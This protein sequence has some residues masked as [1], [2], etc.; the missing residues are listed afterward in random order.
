MS[1]RLKALLPILATVS[2]FCYYKYREAANDYFRFNKKESYS[3]K[4]EFAYQ[5]VTQKLNIVHR[6]RNYVPSP[7]LINYYAMAPAVDF[8]AVGDLDNDGFSDLLFTTATQGD[9]LKVYHNINGLKFEDVG[10]QWGFGQEKKTENMVYAIAV[11]DVNND[12]WLDVYLSRDPCH[13]LYI[14]NKGHFMPAGE[15]YGVSKICGKRVTGIAV[16]DFNRDGFLDLYFT[17]LFG[18]SGMDGG[19][20][21]GVTYFIPRINKASPGAGKNFLLENIQGSKFQLVKNAGLENGFLAWAAGITDVNEDGYPDIIVANDFSVSMVYVNNKNNTFRNETSKT[22]GLQFNS[23]NM[24][25]ETG[26]FNNDGKIDFFVSNVSRS[27]YAANS[28]NYLY[29]KESPGKFKNKSLQNGT[30]RCGWAWGAKF[31]DPNHDG[32][33][34]LMV[35]NGFFNDGPKPYWYQWSIYGTLPQ[36]LVNSPKVMPPSRGHTIEGDQPNCLFMQKQDGTFTDVADQAGIIDQKNGRGLAVIDIENDGDF[37]FVIANHNDEPILYKQVKNNPENNWI[38]LNLRAK[39]KNIFAIG[40]KITFKMGDVERAY[41]HYP[42]NG[43]SSQSHN[44]IIFG[45]GK[46]KKVL[47]H[48]LWPSGTEKTYENLLINKYNTVEE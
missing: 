23:A 38:G 4:L 15:E 31:I 18:D 30:D 39:G 27:T 7:E 42:T 17:R 36:Y 41:E 47:V 22:L 37:D 33:L 44:K 21:N 40:A 29:Q 48:V 46:E 6:T 2:I 35:A 28:Y 16:L 5:N 26:D 10:D 45:L 25:L 13:E 32:R 11:V 3:E 20:P 19:D 43:Y 24:S 12:G 14:N 1:P 34:D 9:A 8:V